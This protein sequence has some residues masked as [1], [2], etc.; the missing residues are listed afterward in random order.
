MRGEGFCGKICSE[1]TKAES[2]LW[3]R[4]AILLVNHHSQHL[5]SYPWLRF[6]SS[7]HPPRLSGLSSFSLFARGNPGCDDRGP[8]CSGEGLW[9]RKQRPGLCQRISRKL[10]RAAA[11]R[12]DVNSL[13]LHQKPMY[14]SCRPL[15]FILPTHK[16]L[17]FSR[18]GFFSPLQNVKK[19]FSAPPFISCSLSYCSTSV[20]SPEW[21][22]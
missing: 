8:C 4:I 6:C 5:W 2:L 14:T 20:M 15:K 11:Q 12:R 17:P 19:C 22:H 3:R 1:T 7:S 16:R 13:D 9:F 21:E 18:I 10:H